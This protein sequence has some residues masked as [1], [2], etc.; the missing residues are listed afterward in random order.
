MQAFTIDYFDETNLCKGYL[1]H[2]R[3]GEKLP[4]VLIS[5][6]WLGLNH[7][8]IEKA[9]EIARLGYIAFAIDVYGEGKTAE[10]TDQAAEL[11]TPFFLDRIMLRKRLQAAY[12]QATK[13][14]EADLS[15]IGAIG[16]CFGGLTVVELLKSGAFLKASVSFHGALGKEL[17][18]KKAALAPSTIDPKS[19]FLLLHGYKDP[20]T[21]MEDVCDLQKELSDAKIDWQSHIYGLAGHA[22]TNPELADKETGDS[23]TKFCFEPLANA[24]S[25]QA[26]NLYFK[27][28][29]S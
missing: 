5:S 23:P 27:E 25:F 1:V 2:P 11:M 20:L 21:S 9:H 15:R 13:I 28:K 12:L 4:I 6:T 29:F 16:F 26:M 17:Q 22:F 18:G 8:T 3:A 10:N 24:R 7:F 14:P 19:S